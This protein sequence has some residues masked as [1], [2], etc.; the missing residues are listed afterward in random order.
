MNSKYLKTKQNQNLETKFFRPFWVLHPI[1]KQT[2]KLKFSKKWKIYNIF[3]MSLLEQD[4]T[5]KGRIDK[6]V[7]QIEFDTGND[8]GEYKVEAI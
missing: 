4:T 3:Y 5:K 2:Y 1:E 6:E 7:K 8:S